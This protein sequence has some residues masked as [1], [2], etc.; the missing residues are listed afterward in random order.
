MAT[1]ATVAMLRAPTREDFRQYLPTWTP[2]L[3]DPP[4]GPV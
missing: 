4:P 2:F 1:A 3:R